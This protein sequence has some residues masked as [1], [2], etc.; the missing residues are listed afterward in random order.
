MISALTHQ[1]HSKNWRA[2]KHSGLTHK[3]WICPGP[4]NMRI[5]L[6][7]VSGDAENLRIS[8]LR[9]YTSRVCIFFSSTWF[10]VTPLWFSALQLSKMY[11]E[12]TQVFEDFHIRL[13]ELSSL[14]VLR[15]LTDLYKSWLKHKTVR[16]KTRRTVRKPWFNSQCRQVKHESKHWHQIVQT[17]H[18][19]V[20]EN[21]TGIQE[22]NANNH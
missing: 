4:P 9:A 20:K 1:M 10:W 22:R 15:E 7:C 12:R 13:H 2:Q 17:M 21:N 5:L 6:K 11:N 3:C 8:K 18:L 19:P 14:Q 16:N